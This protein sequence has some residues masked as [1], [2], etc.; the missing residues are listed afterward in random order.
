[1]LLKAHFERLRIVAAGIDDWIRLNE[2][3]LGRDSR[4]ARE[5]IEKIERHQLKMGQIK[6]MIQSTLAGATHKIKQDV[7]TEVDRFFD[8]RSGN[9]M[10]DLLVFIKNY[11]LSGAE[12]E[13]T[14]DSGGFSRALFMAFQD[15][16][17]AVDSYI[18]G[19]FNPELIRFVRGEEKKIETYF[20]SIAGPYETLI[21]E[22]LTQFIDTL[23]S[24]GIKLS[25]KPDQKGNPPDIESIKN[26]IGLR[27]PSTAATM[28]Y[29]TKIKTEATVRLGFYTVVRFIKGLFHKAPGQKGEKE[30]VA[31]KDGVDRMRRETEKSVAFH[32]KD[33][34]EN[35]KFQYMF[36]L[37]EALSD[38]LYESLLNRFQAYFADLKNFSK[39]A[40]EK[41]I[42]KVSL[43]EEFST[44]RKRS[45]LIQS[46][47][48]QTAGNF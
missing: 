25:R 40:S 12:Y 23:E 14:L 6:S 29:S 9:A 2:D 10:K 33:Y 30:I 3:I 47:I 22:V 26:S 36:K 32:F 34:R 21:E 38:D 18:A 44:L 1:L 19:T 13:E 17:Q 48:E 43:S 42:D 27:V 31:L 46:R 41:R 28:E 11:K 5:I 8:F 7:K 24:L 20:Q 39:Q 37:V 45:R 16:K 35:I 15:F 4:S